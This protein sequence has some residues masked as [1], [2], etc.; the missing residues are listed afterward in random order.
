[1]NTHPY[2]LGRKQE[3]DPQSRSFAIRHLVTTPPRTV[4]WPSFAPILD[5]KNVGAC[6]GFTGA[7]CMNTT[8]FAVARRRVRRSTRYLGNGDGLAFY[9]RATSVDQ[10]PGVYPPEDT[11]SSGLAVCKVLREQGYIGSYRWAFSF[12]EFLRGLQEGPMFVGTPWYDSMFYPDDRG[13]VRPRGAVVGGHEYL[14]LG[15]N[16]RAHDVTFQNSWSVQWGVRGRFRMSFEDFE[17]LL[18]D[19][20]DAG[21]PI[22]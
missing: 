12:D 3:H 17:A 2:P 7:A 1:M 4:L 9:S 19:G 15:V 8:K 13:R 10:W 18:A 21:L 20:G 22:P 5:Q 14:A 6:T 11:G 16:L